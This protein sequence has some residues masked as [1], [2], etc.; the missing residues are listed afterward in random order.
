MTGKN[1]GDL[2][3]AANVTWGWFY[4][5]WIPVRAAN[6]V[7]TCS[8]VY[9]NHYDPFKYYNC[10]AN[11]HHLP[12]SVVSKIG[13]TDQANHQYP[14]GD[15]RSISNP[16]E[17]SHPIHVHLVRFQILDRRPSMKPP[18]RPP[19]RCGLSAQP[20]RPSPTN[21]AGKIRSGALH[22]AHALHHALRRLPGKYVYHC[23]VLEHE[24]NEM[25]RPY[26]V[27]AP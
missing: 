15:F 16:T 12:P 22:D 2:L 3:N 9:N 6:G 17:D 13:Q 26:E 23:H 20:S 21:P 5:D 27:V 1:V 11:P 4:G 14:V 10:T 24:D 18:T 7:V 8:S 25:M 19:A